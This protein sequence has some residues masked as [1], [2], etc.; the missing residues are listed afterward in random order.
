MLI[1]GIR[2]LKKIWISWNNRLKG[3]RWNSERISRKPCISLQASSKTN[4]E[5]NR[6][7]LTVAHA[8][9][10]WRCYF[11]TNSVAAQSWPGDQRHKCGL[12]AT[13]GTSTCSNSAGSQPHHFLCLHEECYEPHGEI[14]VRGVLTTESCLD[15]VN[16]GLTTISSRAKKREA[17]TAG[18]DNY[19]KP[20]ES[21]PATY[22]ED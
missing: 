9:K 19:P 20:C 7:G 2:T 16:R 15:H 22:A 5:R 1:S 3:T 10:P 18:Q 12:W 21:P 17:P 13:G 6:P 14:S 8:K 4:R 11:T